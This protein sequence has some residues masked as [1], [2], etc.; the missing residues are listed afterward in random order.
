MEF[1]ISE[2]EVIKQCAGLKSVQESK[3]AIMRAQLSSYSCLVAFSKE[4]T[5]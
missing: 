1:S 3:L 4:K 5:A 2:C